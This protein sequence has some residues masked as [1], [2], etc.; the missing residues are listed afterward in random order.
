VAS[1][2][3][4]TDGTTEAS[5]GRDGKITLF[6]TSDD[7]SAPSYTDTFDVLI[8][9]SGFTPLPE[10]GPEPHGL[11]GD[12]KKFYLLAQALIRRVGELGQ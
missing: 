1:K 8:A 3:D 7:P 9:R 12:R 11:T 5:L 6:Y 10:D 4:F 2:G